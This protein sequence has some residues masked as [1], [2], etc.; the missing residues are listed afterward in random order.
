MRSRPTRHS[1][2]L[3]LLPFFVLLVTC[4]PALA[5]SADGVPLYPP[6]VDAGYSDATMRSPDMSGPMIGVTILPIPPAFTPGRIYGWN[7]ETG[8]NWPLGGATGLTTD[9]R[10]AAVLDLGGTVYY[11][12]QQQD[13]PATTSFDIWLWKGN[14]A[15]T[16]DLGFPKRLVASPTFSNQFAA[17]IGVVTE[18]DGDHIVVA[19]SDDRLSAPASPQVYMLD[20]SKDTDGDTTPDYLEAGFDPA[21]AGTR[22]DPSGDLTKG[23]LLPAVGTKGIFWLDARNGTLVDSQ[24]Q[25]LEVWRADLSSGAPVAALF[26]KN[27]EAGDGLDYLRATGTG[28]AWLRTDVAYAG[29]GWEP[30]AKAVGGSGHTVAWLAA[31]GSFDVSGSAYAMTGGHGGAT[32]GDS[33][34]WFSKTLGGQAIPVCNVGS[35]Y[36]GAGTLV[37]QIDPTISTAPGGYRIVWCDSR[38][39]HNTPA[40]LY[41]DLSYQLYVA[42][43]PTVTG[44]PD[45]ARVEH[46]HRVTFTVGVAPNFSGVNVRLQKG[47]RHVVH[48]PREN[49]VY[50]TGWSTV[51]TKE[52]SAASKA[53]LSWT[54]SV[55]GTYYLRV[56]FPGGKRY[57]DVG[58]RKVPHVPK[59]SR[60]VRIVVH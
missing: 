33:D 1:P 44:G 56:F 46:G 60:I 17:D 2:L 11:V 18:A 55:P 25:D 6:G 35:Y 15:G 24:W 3:A 13:D 12:W 21:T 37:Q 23:Q 31:P 19:W 49:I 14:E 30:Y 41:D 4:A 52:L 45:H 7:A 22:V 57:T 28:A 38:Q 32:D 9:Q 58:D 59:V 42:L 36:G 27:A 50:F 26:F 43:V 16:P 40:T 47:R 54:P 53:R 10:G 29:S 8:T 20:L 51:K 39:V 48:T 5:W 34:I